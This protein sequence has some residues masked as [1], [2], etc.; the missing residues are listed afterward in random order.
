MISTAARK[1]KTVTEKTIR[2]E[3]GE[4]SYDVRIGPGM[5]TQLGAAAVALDGVTAAVVICDSN[6]AK[7]YGPQATESLRQAGLATETIDFP[8]GEAHKTLAT[9]GALFDKLFSVRP[10]VDRRTLIVAAGGGVTGDVAGFVAATAL[11][12]LRWIQCPTTLLADVD[13]SV[14]GKTAVDHPRAI[15]SSARSTSRAACSSTSRR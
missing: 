9:C 7:L 14:G 15:T 6:V 13:A 12:G 8:A 3:L 11:R 2:V 1:G 10:A 5:L 4:R